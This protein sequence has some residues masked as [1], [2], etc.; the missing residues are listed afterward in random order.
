MKGLGQ[1]LCVSTPWERMPIQSSATSAQ[2]CFPMPHETPWTHFS[3]LPH[4]RVSLCPLQLVFIPPVPR[5][6][7]FLVINALSCQSWPLVLSV[8][9]PPTHPAGTLLPLLPLE[10][11]HSPFSPCLT[12]PTSLPWGPLNVRGHRG[13]SSCL[14][15]IFFP[16]SSPQAV[17]T[18][19]TLASLQTPTPEPHLTRHT[20][21]GTSDHT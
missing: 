10:I 2:I 15:S 8:F 1:S 5:N 17:N 6:G 11:A 3:P 19:E 7:S 14:F 13:L 20:T 21:P 16:S 18:M 12:S 4:L 9:Y